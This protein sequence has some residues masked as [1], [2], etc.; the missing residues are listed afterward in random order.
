MP[1]EDGEY[2]F[3]SAAPAGGHNYLAVRSSGQVFSATLDAHS[4]DQKVPIRMPSMTLESYIDPLFLIL[5]QWRIAKRP[6]GHFDVSSVGT[7]SSLRVN[8]PSKGD[9]AYTLNVHGAKDVP[10][11]L[12]EY[13][14]HIMFV[15][16]CSPQLSLLIDRV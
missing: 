2:R 10:W 16:S 6:D 13:H 7:K 3:K 9:I 14:G 5:T 11:D 1:L 15:L 8:P 4:E 12:E